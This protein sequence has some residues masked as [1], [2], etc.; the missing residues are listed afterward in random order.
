MSAVPELLSSMRLA[1]STRIVCPDCSYERKKSNEKDLAIH[2]THDGWKYYCHHCMS[3]GFVAFNK[4]NYRKAENNV[5][6]M[7]TLDTSKLQTQH[8]DFL[9]SRGISA[10]TAEIMQLFPAEKY[11]PAVYKE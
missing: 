1:P 3:S 7:R 11:F 10:K 8:Y 4:T 9:K 6:P 2:E 5:I